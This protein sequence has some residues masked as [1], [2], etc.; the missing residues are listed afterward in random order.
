MAKKLPSKKSAPSRS[1]ARPAAR[2]AARGASR[3]GKPA[4]KAT[5]A[6]RGKPA[7]KAAAK[8]SGKFA[9]IP[10]AKGTSSY[11]AKRAAKRAKGGKK[12][13]GSGA[14][15]G[16]RSGAGKSGGG[17]SGGKSA[18]GKSGKGPS[19]LDR[20]GPA[21]VASQPKGKPK[22]RRVTSAEPTNPRDEPRR[23]ALEAARA[24]AIEAARML[25]DDRCEDVVVL[26]IATVSQLADFVVIGTGTSDRQM[27]GT[28]SDISKIG[29]ETG[30]PCVRRNIDDR[31]TWVL[32]DFVDVIVHIFEP[33]ARAFYDLEMM[34]GDVPKI[35]WTRPAGEKPRI[36]PRA[37][38]AEPDLLTTDHPHNDHLHQHEDTSP[39][40][41]EEAVY[42]EA[43][44]DADADS[45][46]N[47][48][49]A[50]SN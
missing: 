9:S 33:N 42:D 43:A 14:A 11:A 15:A 8:D 28:G 38:A 12:P 32:L 7:G 22:S 5:A 34:W 2:P 45:D 27:R 16:A 47:A 23:R 18:A 21:A 6:S 1:S 37:A 19:T 13:I 17:Q 50:A 48:D 39:P 46:A 44:E 41:E 31:T 24:F 36:R 40:T 3:G 49:E 26:E 20:F 35:A 30:F 4:G 29:E 25:N 10:G